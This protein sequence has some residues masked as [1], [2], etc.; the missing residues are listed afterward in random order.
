MRDINRKVFLLAIA[1]CLF[2]A[3]VEAKPNLSGTWKL[4]VAKSDFGPL[5]APSAR[6]DKIEQSDPNLKIAITQSGEQG[7]FTYTMAYTTDGK[8]STNVLRGN[9][10]K[11]TA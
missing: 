3:R 9:T 10:F 4:N 2:S 6:T 1:A 8:E 11:S 5:P 7:E